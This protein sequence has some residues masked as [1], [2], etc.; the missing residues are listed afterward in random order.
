[1]PVIVRGETTTQQQPHSN[2]GDEWQVRFN[3]LSGKRDHPTDR[4]STN[5]EDS[6]EGDEEERLQTGPQLGP[7][8]SAR[9]MGRGRLF[10]DDERSLLPLFRLT[11][12]VNRATRGCRCRA[13]ADET[14]QQER[15]LREADDVRSSVS[16]VTDRE[17]RT[18]LATRN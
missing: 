14:S 8:R 5:A 17:V 1:M 15:R 18:L 9:P 16:S 12:D 13:D 7:G 4:M 10:D 11:D 3:A 6:D 2:S